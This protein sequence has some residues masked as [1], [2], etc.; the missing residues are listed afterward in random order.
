MPYKCSYCFKD[1]KTKHNLNKHSE[2]CYFTITSKNDYLN[3]IDELKDDVPNIRELFNFI[4]VLSLKV[5]KLEDDNQKLKKYINHK[6]I[7]VDP[8]DWLNDNRTPHLDFIYWYKSIDTY[9]YL[10][11]V[12]NSNL[13]KAVT[14]AISNNYGEL[15]PLCAFDNKKFKLYIFNDE[16][17]KEI[18]DDELNT[19]L[20][21]LCNQ[22]IVDFNTYLSKN[23]YLF[24][25]DSYSDTYTNYQNNVYGDSNIEKRNNQI[26]IS[27]W[28]KIKFN[29]STVQIS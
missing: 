14:E 18:N 5:K 6:L 25:N 23:E 21:F 17:W 2:F 24:C 4:N 16:K 28:Q 10:E 27:L 22:F 9:S 26:K 3:D 15:S 13:I 7:K 20:N 12:F 1:F 8:L 29:V 11:T 19:A